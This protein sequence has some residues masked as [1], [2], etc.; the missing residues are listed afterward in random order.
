[1]IYVNTYY[2]NVI[3]KIKNNIKILE[4]NKAIALKF[5]DYTRCKEIKNEIASLHKLLQFNMK[6]NEK[7]SDGNCN[8]DSNGDSNEYLYGNIKYKNRNTKNFYVN[9]YRKMN[10]H[11]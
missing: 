7:L 8:G 11:F 1:M 10:N 2:Y 4:K 3:D 6:C 5:N 9:D